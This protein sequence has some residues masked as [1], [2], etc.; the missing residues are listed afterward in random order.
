[1]CMPGAHR[2]QKKVLDPLP[3]ELQKVVS[4]HVD[5]GNNLDPLQE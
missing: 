3:L 1:M 4:Y 2:S 5:A